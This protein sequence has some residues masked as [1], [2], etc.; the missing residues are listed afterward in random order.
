LSERLTT[1]KEEIDKKFYIFFFH[2]IFPIQIWQASQHLLV[3]TLC[4]S[5]FFNLQKI[6]FCK[7]W[8]LPSI[9][10]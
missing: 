9:S 3:W 4:L 10:H 7:H 6:V 1:K 8:N 5:V 2:P